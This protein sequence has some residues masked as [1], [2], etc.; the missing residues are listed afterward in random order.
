MTWLPHLS[1]WHCRCSHDDR[2]LL[3]AQRCRLSR[4]VCGMRKMVMALFGLALLAAPVAAQDKPVDIHFGFGW[5][6]PTSDFAD[7]FDSGWNGG[8][9]ATFNINEHL[10]VMAEY[11]Y[12]RMDGPE[13]QITVF[14]SPTN[15]TG[16]SGL[17][18][19]NHQMHVGDFNLVYK[20]QHPDRAI[21]GYVLGGG[22]IYHRLVQLTTPS[23]G[24]TSVC[25]P[26]WYVCYPTL[27]SVDT[28]IGDRSSNDF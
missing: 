6:F 28:I 9:G 18:E 4:G 1:G 13:R 17:I 16:S 27:V 20:M 7:R 26:Y 11:T 25:D 12:N 2:R 14:P 3:L 19:S 8:I 10:G 15:V 24:Y 23:V 22:G 5:T 21:G